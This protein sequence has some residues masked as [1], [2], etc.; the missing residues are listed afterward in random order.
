MPDKPVFGKET[1]GDCVIR[2]LIAPGKTD[3]VVYQ[4]QGSVFTWE[5]VLDA[6]S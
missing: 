2:K 1:L 5:N 4:C 3:V 6:K